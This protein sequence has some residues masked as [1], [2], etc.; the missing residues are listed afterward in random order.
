MTTS[1]LKITVSETQEAAI[2]ALFAH[3]G[4]DFIVEEGDE[5]RYT[6]TSDTQHARGQT[7][8][9]AAPCGRQGR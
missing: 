1:T 9:L 4:W 8:G 7:R 3:S 5:V 2:R 6:S